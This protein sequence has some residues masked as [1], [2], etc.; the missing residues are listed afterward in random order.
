MALE[1]VDRDI[2]ALSRAIEDSRASL[3]VLELDQTRELLDATALG[4]ES[5][6]AWA[7]A[8]A[9]LVHAWEL[10]SVLADHLDRVRSLRGTRS[11]VPDE[12]LA[13][14]D[15][16]LHARVLVVGP[17]A[18][19]RSAKELLSQCSAAAA[20]AHHVVSA[21]AQ[22]WEALV[23]RLTTVSA[24]VRA[25]AELLDDLGVAP[26]EALAEARREL[27]RLTDAVAKDP[28]AATPEQVGALETHVGEA[29]ADVERVRDFAGDVDGRL[30]E[31]RVLL[32]EARRAEADARE[33]HEAARAKIAA[34]EAPAPS[35]LPPDLVDELDRAIDLARAG[36]WREADAALAS[37]GARATPARDA[38]R[39]VADAN[40][41]PI[42]HRDELRGRLRAYEAK[43]RSLRKLE[44]PG[45]DALR[46]RAHRVLHSAPT[47][48]A[49]AADL[50]RR[51]QQGLSAAPESEALR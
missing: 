11:R 42:A 46:S 17:S 15:E 45:L 24:T 26:T 49:E 37:W 6:T 51:Y 20:E 40:R 9:G 33:A 8:S 16:L 18:E 48:L 19:R 3:L 22:A 50:L 7:T 38:A 12:R 39:R 5:A 4:G 10:Q 25:C 44:D 14:L 36:G 47:D 28:L 23:P 35:P 41:A 1:I 2:R 21:A 27:A 30:E 13:E 29:R 43:A 31:A 32:A 34:V